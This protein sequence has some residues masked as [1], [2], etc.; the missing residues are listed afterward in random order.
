[1]TVLSPVKV[2]DHND[3]HYYLVLDWL[4]LAVRMFVVEQ[5]R[6]LP[7]LFA[8]LVGHRS[9]GRSFARENFLYRV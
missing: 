1:M 5:K 7:L 3:E 9:R 4:N 6:Q 2:L 8:E